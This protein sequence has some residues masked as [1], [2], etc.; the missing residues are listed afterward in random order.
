MKKTIAFIV[1]ALLIM[2]FAACNTA[3][4]VE[5]APAAD[6]PEQG[7]TEPT[8]TGG[9][10]EPSPAEEAA[11]ETGP[12]EVKM[13]QTAPEVLEAMMENPQEL[14]R[15][16][17]DEMAENE[18]GQFGSGAAEKRINEERMELFS[19]DDAAYISL[20]T[21]LRDFGS[22]NRPQQAILVK[23]QPENVSSLYFD[24]IGMG[25]F[26][27]SFEQNDVY[28]VDI[29]AAQKMIFSDS[30]PNS[31]NFKWDAVYY[32]LLAFDDQANVRCVVWEENFYEN[33]A[34]FEASLYSGAD[35]IYESNWQM[36]INFD[37]G[38]Q[39]NIYEYAVYTF[40][41]L[42]ENPPVAAGGGGEGGEAAGFWSVKI[43]DFDAMSDGI[44]GNVE[45]IELN[46]AGSPCAGYRLDALLAFADAGGASGAIVVFEDGSTEQVPDLSE[47]FLVFMRDGQDLGKPYLGYRDMVYETS[48]AEIRPN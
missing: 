1:T 32:L 41:S 22:D 27:I 18:G 24:F 28:F 34:Y 25:E 43:G 14:F 37:G 9:T 20:N 35:D 42:T 46:V 3:G 15:E 19:G 48:V 40:D 23:F 2:S 31:F 11:P 39:L 26:S 36:A 45:T 8:P 21:R 5:S 13:P 7:T 17:R 30:I 44:S 29:T 4:P 12:E 10:A 38:G 16:G 33:Q 6:V 47:A